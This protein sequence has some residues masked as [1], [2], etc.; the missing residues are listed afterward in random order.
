MEPFHFSSVARHRRFNDSNRVGKTRG[1]IC[2]ETRPCKLPRKIVTWLQKQPCHSLGDDG[3]GLLTGSFSLRRY[4]LIQPRRY[5]GKIDRRGRD[6]R[7]MT[8]ALHASIVTWTEC[9]CVS[10][11]FFCGGEHKNIYT[12]A[13]NAF[14]RDTREIFMGRESGENRDR[15]G[16]QLLNNITR[17]QLVSSWRRRK[18]RKRKRKGSLNFFLSSFLIRPREMTIFAK[19]FEML[20]WN[21]RRRKDAWVFFW[22]F[23]FFSFW[24]KRKLNGSICKNFKK[25][26]T[27]VYLRDLTNSL[28]NLLLL[29]LSKYTYRQCNDNKRNDLFKNDRRNKFDNS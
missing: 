24:F 10:F 11:F 9:E 28:R 18:E 23:L 21:T 26:E 29:L 8:R 3:N 2:D 13:E 14:I 5:P 25:E 27:R 1:W 17:V 19:T 15:H 20:W 4:F 16:W 6:S 12:P 7:M 22:I